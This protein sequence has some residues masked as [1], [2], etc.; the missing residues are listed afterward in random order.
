MKVLV[1]EDEAVPRRLLEA[2]LR[3]WGYEVVTASNGVEALKILRAPDAPKL[4]ILDWMMPGMNG[5]EV[6][7]EVRH[8]LQEPYTYILLLTGKRNRSDI[9]QG[10]EAGAD[11]YI[12]KPFDMEELKVRLR[13]GKRIV[14]LQQQLISSRDAMR[15]LAMRDALTGLWN[16]AAI[17]DFLNNELARAVRHQTQVAIVLL[18]IDYFK[19]V[20]DKHGHLAGDEAL[21]QV[22]QT[23]RT[24]TRPYD[25]VGRF[26]GEEFLVVLPGCDVANALSHAERQRHAVSQIVLSLRDAKISLTISAGVAMFDPKEIVNATELIA[27]A[28]AALYWAKNHGRNRVELSAGAESVTE[29]VNEL[30]RA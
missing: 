12:T 19:S 29:N 8:Q 15:D 20:N 27:R 22:A 7:Q 21:R 25:A 10:L 28:D 4:A 2:T 24:T 26:G 23:L 11:D 9:I 1:A 5:P 30:I 3:R 17:I 13:T 6:C 14:F 16:R 18:D